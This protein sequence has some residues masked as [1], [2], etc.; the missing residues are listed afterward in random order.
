[1]RKVTQKKMV[2]DGYYRCSECGS[3]GS[4]IKAHYCHHCGADMRGEEDDSNRTM[5]VREG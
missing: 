1:M 3:R 2:K 5:P 4:A